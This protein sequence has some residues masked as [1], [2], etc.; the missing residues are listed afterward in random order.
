MRE[1]SIHK[2]SVNSALSMRSKMPSRLW[3][4]FTQSYCFFYM[5]SKRYGRIIHKSKWHKIE[6]DK[7]M[8]ELNKRIAQQIQSQI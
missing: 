1:L 8:I 2:S 4:N 7:Q 3:R 5:V 6:Y